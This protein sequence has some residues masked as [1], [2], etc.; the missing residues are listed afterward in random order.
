MEPPIFLL[1]SGSQPV[2]KGKG[3]RY[4]LPWNGTRFTKA[5][6]K[7]KKAAKEA[8]ARKREE[9]T[10]PNYEISAG[11]TTTAI[12][13]LDLT[14]LRLDHVKAYNSE[15]HYNTYKYQARR[16]VQIWGQLTCDQITQ[17]MV[18][19]HLLERRKVSAYTANKTLRYLRATWNFGVR[20]KL[21]ANNPTDGIEFFPVDKKVKY[22]P[23]A[24][25]L[26]KVIACADPD[27]QDYLWA[28]RETIWVGSAR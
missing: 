21:V 2:T 15:S 10:N 8:K 4:E 18:Q 3:W 14:N 16:W 24:E 19:Q 1:A 17:A 13:F 12:T 11:T 20:L 22:V 28:I 9:L 26:D 6:F 25:D 27:T 7:T 5:G 23:S